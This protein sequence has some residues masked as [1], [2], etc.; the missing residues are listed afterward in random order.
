MISIERG[1]LLGAVIGVVLGWPECTRAPWQ[2]AIDIVIGD[3]LL[4]AVV[5]ALAC[6]LLFG[7]RKR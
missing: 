7:N 3:A 5:V 6:R 4:G 2:V 1:A